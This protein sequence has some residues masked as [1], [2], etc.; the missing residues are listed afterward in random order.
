MKLLFIILAI[1]FLANTSIACTDFSGNYQATDSNSNLTIIQK[2]CEELAWDWGTNIEVMILDDV[3]RKTHS[4][5]YVTVW[6]GSAFDRYQETIIYQF[7]SHFKDGE[8]S[9]GTIFIKQTLHGYGRIGI[10]KGTGTY[11]SDGQW[12]WGPDVRHFIKLI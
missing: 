4:D 2:G 6:A 1:T 3:K 10:S 8:I 5:D 7:E 12:V 9:T 11:R